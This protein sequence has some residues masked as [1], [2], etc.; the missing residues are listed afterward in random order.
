[1]KTSSLPQDGGG[2]SPILTLRHAHL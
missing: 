1:M 2:W